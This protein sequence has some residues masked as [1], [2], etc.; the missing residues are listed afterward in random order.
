MA[1][2]KVELTVTRRVKV[3]TPK[4][5]YTSYPYRY[6]VPFSTSRR[7]PITGQED[8]IVSPDQWTGKEK[9]TASQKEKLQ[10]G[11]NPFIIDPAVPIVIIHGYIYND[12]YVTVVEKDDK[13][14]DKEIERTYKNPKDHAE[15]TALLANPESPVAK[16]K[17]EYNKNKH[18]FYIEDKE[19][20]AQAEID[21]YDL[22]YEA[23]QFAR[24]DLGTGRWAELIILLG[25]EIPEYKI[26]P[27]LLSD[28]KMKAYVLRGCKEHPDV[29]LKM[30]GVDAT[31]T[32]FVIKLL[33]YAIISRG[34]N[35]EYFYGDLHVGHTFDSIK[36]FMET[37]QNAQ[38]VTK[39]QNMIDSFE[40]KVSKT[41]MLE[42]VTK[43]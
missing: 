37:H 29:V 41:E 39:W 35:M 11:N 7:L 20:E 18:N 21:K 19:V 42:A 33:K 30:K 16:S 27:G 25:H 28:A 23:E 31:K 8:I 40:R 24:K 43:E 13:G 34:K 32:I 4:G 10:M 1:K 38:I 2:E 17:L 9:L 5:K 12:D 22:A 15:L 6:T 3:I 26:E 14:K 36:G